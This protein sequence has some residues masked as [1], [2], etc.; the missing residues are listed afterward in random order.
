MKYDAAA[1]QE[2]AHSSMVFCCL[3]IPCPSTSSHYQAGLPDWVEEHQ[4]DYF[5]QP[6]MP[7]NLVLATFLNTGDHFERF[8]TAVFCKYF[9]S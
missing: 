9:V 2:K 1:I 3:I 6:F 4:L 7:Y 8:P 5:W